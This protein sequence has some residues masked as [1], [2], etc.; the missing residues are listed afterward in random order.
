MILSP[1]GSPSEK[2]PD[3]QSS[4]MTIRR[5]SASVRANV[6]DDDIFT[7][8]HHTQTLRRRSS[9]LSK[10]LEELRV[11]SPTVQPSD[12]LNISTNVEAVGTECNPYLAYPHLSLATVRRSMDDAT[13][14]YD[15]VVV[16]D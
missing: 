7:T 1:L 2:R 12:D 13:S 15:Y 11:D 16:D 4:G 3:S 9:R 10:W 6:G 8:Q 14:M 5:I